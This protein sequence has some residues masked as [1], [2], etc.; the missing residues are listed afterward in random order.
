MT[1]IE[2]QNGTIAAQLRAASYEEKD[3]SIGV[4]WSTGA[5]VRRRGPSGYYDETLDMSPGAVNLSRLNSGAPFLNAHADRSLSDV[6][7]SVIP[8]SARILNGQGVA[9]IKLSTAPGDAD[10]ISKIRDGVVR[11]IS[12]GYEIHK[13]EIVERD[14]DVPIYRATSWTPLEISA[15]PIPADAGAGIVQARS[16]SAKSSTVSV[17]TLPRYSVAATRLRMMTKM[18]QR[19]LLKPE[20]T[21]NH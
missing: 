16:K 9:R 7:G 18:Q 6:I 11:N 17:S 4:V 1:K 5:P 13:I 20:G 10:H 3:N 15:V 14:G 19:G 21:T 12:I 8:G 2:L